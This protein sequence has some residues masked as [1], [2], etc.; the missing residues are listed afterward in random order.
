MKEQNISLK[1]CQSLELFEYCWK[2]FRSLHRGNIGSLAHR[3]AKLLAIK[4]RV[5]IDTILPKKF[6][7]RAFSGVPEMGDMDMGVV[8]MMVF[9]FLVS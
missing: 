5:K 2:V 8:I 6:L 9:L 1:C 7:F 4:V 3:P